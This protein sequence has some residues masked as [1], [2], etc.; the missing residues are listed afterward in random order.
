MRR[1]DGQGSKAF[2]YHFLTKKIRPHDILPI[3]STSR[4]V[5]NSCPTRNHGQHRTSQDRGRRPNG[6]PRAQRSALLQQV[7]IDGG[8]GLQSRDLTVNWH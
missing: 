7:H 1:I 4:P 2:F 8:L 3:T 6:R 5:D